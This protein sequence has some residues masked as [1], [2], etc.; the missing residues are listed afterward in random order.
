MQRHVDIKIR[1]IPC[2]LYFTVGLM[3]ELNAH[4]GTMEI[5]DIL[6]VEGIEGVKNLSYVA[7][8]L[9]K[10]GADIF[11][12]DAPDLDAE[13]LAKTM[14]HYEYIEI[15]NAVIRAVNLGFAR[16]IPD[17]YRDLGLEELQKKTE[18]I[19]G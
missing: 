19:E 16:E 14:Q 1:D 3:Y 8:A 15:S 11:G 13:M 12:D 18:K 6:N 4:F 10:N 7:L 5:S 2:K 9:A 17:Q